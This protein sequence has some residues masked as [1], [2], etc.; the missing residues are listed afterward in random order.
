M[1][2]KL[3]LPFV[4]IMVT[5]VCNISCRG[6]TNYSDLPHA[7]YLT[8]SQGRAEIEPWLERIEILD[9]GILGGEPLINPDIRN[10]I[11]GLRKLLPNAQLRF[12]TNGL[13]LEKNFDIVDLLADVG[14]CVF[15][16]TVHV[17]NSSLEATIQKVMDRFK[18]NP[19]FEHGINRYVTNNGFR[20]QVN[21]PVMFT[22]SFLGSYTTMHPHNNRPED[23]FEICSQKSCPL[24]YNGRLYKCST[25]GLL[26][27]TLSR[28]NWPNS[29]QWKPYIQSGIGVDCSDIELEDFINNFN[30]PHSMCSMCPSTLDTGSLLNHA[31]N[32]IEK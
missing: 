6:C 32:V 31:E 10:W 26:V 9:F 11:T 22:K 19:I 3:V 21:R 24:L 23:A 1:T 12:T 17:D 30:Q 16:V 7:G 15:K 5:Q 13:L 25:S 29:E 28:F 4:E 18:W 14:N 2:K 27:D 20:F 8:W